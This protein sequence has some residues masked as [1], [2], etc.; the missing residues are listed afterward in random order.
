MSSLSSFALGVLVAREVSAAEFGAFALSFT[1]YGYLVIVTRVL[2]S[3]PLTV[4]FS[5]AAPSAA[6]QAARQSTGAAIV[7]GLPPAAALAL[8]GVLLGGTVGPT[9]VLTAVLLPGLLLQDAWRMV[10]FA[11]GRPRAAAAIDSAWAVVQVCLMLMLST[12]DQGSAVAYLGVW[13]LSGWLAALLGA[14]LAGLVPA[15][16]ATWQWLKAHWDLSRYFVT[17]YVL[18]NGS[19]QLMLVLVAATGG[20]AVAGALRG[21]QVLTGPVG[22]L[23]TSGMAFAIPELA[24]RPWTVG[25]RLIRAGV[26]ISGTVVV[27][28]TVW[29]ALLLVLP[30]EVGRQLMGDTWTGVDA[31]L[32]PTVLGLVM[33]ASG[34]G[35]TCGILA[36]QRPKVLFWLQIIAAPAYLIGGLVGVLTGGA[37]GAAVGIALAHTLGA[38]F[39]WIRLVVV[40]RQAAEAR[41][42]A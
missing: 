12:T 33:S 34:L 21:A 1:V 37:F 5:D 32:V 20:L 16:R 15:P 10:F 9:L 25:R 29:G 28:A 17:E 7:V 26:G 4:R 2:V 23:V 30:E 24:R 27:L 14:L 35:P 6:R 22:I 13:G 11:A 36:A 18:I 31:I 3:Q 40:A 8:T 19:T 41:E 38:G 42:H 39:A